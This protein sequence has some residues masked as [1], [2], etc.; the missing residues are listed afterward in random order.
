[1]VEPYAE[2]L[3]Q[4]DIEVGA[5]GDLIRFYNAVFV[6]FMKEFVLGFLPN[7]DGVSMYDKSMF[8]SDSIG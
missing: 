2:L 1:M 7:D 8:H 5:R 4:P 3:Y 6:G